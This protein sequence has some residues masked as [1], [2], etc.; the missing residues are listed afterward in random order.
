MPRVGQ[1]PEETPVDDLARRLA[2]LEGIEAVTFKEGTGQFASTFATDVITHGLGVV[3][4]SVFIT[5]RDTHSGE[6]WV[7]TETTTTFTAN[8]GT[9]LGPIIDFYW[10]AIP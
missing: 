5:L 10:L 6:L 7:D 3:P 9:P 8:R 1:Y 4:S 2:I